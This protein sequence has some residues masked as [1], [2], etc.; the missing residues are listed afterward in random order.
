MISQDR[1]S[2]SISELLIQNACSQEPSMKDY[3]LK[4][5]AKVYK[6]NLN[7]LAPSRQSVKEIPADKNFILKN[8]RIANA[9]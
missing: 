7:K 2:K 1:N 4:M 3:R 8:K 9:S 6:Q 5:Q